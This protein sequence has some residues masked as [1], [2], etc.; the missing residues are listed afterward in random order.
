[1]HSETG[2]QATNGLYR[3]ST[4]SNGHSQ[5]LKSFYPARIRESGTDWLSGKKR[6]AARMTAAQ[7]LRAINA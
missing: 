7:V 2:T 4:V 6:A 5:S 3:H 1:V